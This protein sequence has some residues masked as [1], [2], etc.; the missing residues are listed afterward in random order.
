MFETIPLYI[1]TVDKRPAVVSNNSKSALMPFLW[2]KKL[3]TLNA[4]EKN[5][6]STVYKYTFFYN[7]LYKIIKFSVSNLLLNLKSLMTQI[8]FCSQI[9]GLSQHGQHCPEPFWSRDAEPGPLGDL[10]LPGQPQHLRQE[11]GLLPLV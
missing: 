3:L 5:D 8:G 7:W 1:I 10:L 4:S 11:H 2:C 6:Y 9:E